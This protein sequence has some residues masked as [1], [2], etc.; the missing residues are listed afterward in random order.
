MHAPAGDLPL[1]VLRLLSSMRHNGKSVDL[2]GAGPAFTLPANIGDMDP[3]IK[4]LD[5]GE[6]NLTGAAC[7]YIFAFLSVTS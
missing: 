1:P 5:L 4:E 3:A 7:H 2:K 6:C